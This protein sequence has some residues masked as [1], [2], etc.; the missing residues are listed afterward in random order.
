MVV[1][2]NGQRRIEVEGI[3]GRSAGQGYPVVGG[4]YAESLGGREGLGMSTK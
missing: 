1:G 4:H 2:G 3:L